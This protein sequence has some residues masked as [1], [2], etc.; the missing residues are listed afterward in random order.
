MDEQ[1]EDAS[2]ESRHATSFFIFAIAIVLLG[3][4]SLYA[5][6]NR[7]KIS[8]FLQN[9]TR[10]SP[11]GYLFLTLTE[12]NDDVRLGD[13][14]FYALDIETER[15]RKVSVGSITPKLSTDKRFTAFVAGTTKGMG[16][17]ILDHTTGE[18]REIS[19]NN[20]PFKREPVWSSD[21]STVAYVATQASTHEEDGH[22]TPER[23]EVYVVDI[24]GEERFI[25]R[26]YS[27]V[28]SPDGNTLLILRNDGLW[29]YDIS[30]STPV[31]RVV[32]GIKGEADDMMKI[33]LSPDFKK[34]AW[35]NHHSQ[36]V[37]LF[38]IDDWDALALRSIEQISGSVVWSV[39]SP[40]STHLAMEVFDDVDG[41]PENPRIVLRDL[42]SGK[43]KLLQ[44][45]KGYNVDYLWITDWATFI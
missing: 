38:E 29:A 8:D 45:L 19:S 31:G 43:E 22:H 41:K 17:H 9:S 37:A 40:D 12:K 26:G 33:N 13:L 39:F 30:S 15:L 34:L 18:V 35:S 16:V 21:A 6:W 10:P 7:E 20:M 5:L 28:F 2:F 11:S 42:S 25:A 4:G 23:W 3:L 27:P 24:S 14:S 44:S 1:F 32:W 36:Q